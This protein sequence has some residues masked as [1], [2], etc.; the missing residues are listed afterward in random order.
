MSFRPEVLGFSGQ[1]TMPRISAY[2]VSSHLEVPSCGNEPIDSGWGSHR[3][4]GLQYAEATLAMAT[5]LLALSACNLLREYSVY[6]QSWD[7]QVF[8]FT[9]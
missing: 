1:S 8:N 9:P 7:F 6:G 4:E 2:T 5:A 3:A